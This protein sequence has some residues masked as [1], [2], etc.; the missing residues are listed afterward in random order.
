MD[1]RQDS[2]PTGGRPVPPPQTPYVGAESL[3]G[4]IRSV[5]RRADLSQRE[6]ADAAGLARSTVAK[7]EA[8]TLTPSLNTL[9]RI[10]AAADLVLVVADRDGNVVQPMRVWD[11]TLDGGDKKF[12]AHLD[13]ILDPRAGDWWGDQYGL[14]R[15]PET[16]HRSRAYRDAKRALSQWSVRVAQHRYEPPPPD[17]DRPVRRRR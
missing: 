13:L 12:P 4:L 7:A 14:A 5:R 16:Y 15:P 8:G 17:P 11:D 9:L 2:E 3:P 6:L 10:L 1:E